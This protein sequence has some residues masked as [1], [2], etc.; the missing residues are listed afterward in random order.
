MNRLDMS[1][2]IDSVQKLIEDG[3]GDAAR[4]THILA[5]LESGKSLYISDAK[6]LQS[7]LSSSDTQSG[8][9]SNISNSAQVNSITITTTNNIEG[10]TILEYLGIVSGEAVMSVKIFRE[11]FAGIHDV[12]GGRSGQF[13]KKFREA[14]KVSIAEMIDQAKENGANAVVGVSVDYEMVGESMMI[15]SHGTSVKVVPN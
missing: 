4:L 6:Y 13:E 3:D 1:S 14:K 2:L 11:T 10:S 7:L 5:T 12:V 8:T 15:S 9:D